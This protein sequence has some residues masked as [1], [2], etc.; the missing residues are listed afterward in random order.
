MKTLIISII[1]TSFTACLQ[2]QSL[3]RHVLGSA[4]ATLNFSS[5]ASM[6]FTIGEF[7]VGTFTAT[8][9]GLPQT[10]Y[11]L[12]QGFHQ[13]LSVRSIFR[14]AT[15]TYQDMEDEAIKN[16]EMA[17]LKAGF[18]FKIY[19]NPTEDIVNLEM[20][21]NV[22][23]N[24]TYQLINM[25]GQVLDAGNINNFNSKLDLSKSETGIYILI[26][27]N[28]ESKIDKSYRIIKN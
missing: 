6:D 23:G 27:R 12:S 22:P 20:E 15:G 24:T 7:A 14:T 3:D 4:G 5:K 11:M 25:K 8:S 21:G 16:Q 28:A 9:S 2:A 1:L 18:N 10:T 17:D 13:G 19:P 26:L